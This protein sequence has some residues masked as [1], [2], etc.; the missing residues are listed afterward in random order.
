MVEGRYAHEDKEICKAWDDYKSAKVNGEIIRCL[1][2]GEHDRLTA[3]HGKIKLPGVSM[4]AVPLISINA[5]SFASYGKTA[6]D[7]AAQI[8]EKASYAYVTALN[9]LISDSIHKSELLRIRLF[10]GLKATTTLRQR[11]SAGLLNLRKAMQI[12]LTPL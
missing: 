5:E 6:N 7:P 9:D 8:G 1:V 11:H 12:N 4:G 3:L 2:S 10:T